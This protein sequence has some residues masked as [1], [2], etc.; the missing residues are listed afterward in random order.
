MNCAHC[1]SAAGNKD[2]EQS[3]C[4]T[5]GYSIVLPLCRS[6]YCRTEFITPCQLHFLKKFAKDRWRT[7]IS[8]Q[9]KSQF[10][11]FHFSASH[12]I[13]ISRKEH[14]YGTWKIP[15]KCLMVW[16][17]RS[18]IL[19]VMNKLSFVG[20]ASIVLL[21]PPSRGPKYVRS[22]ASYRPTP[23]GAQSPPS[24][25][26]VSMAINELFDETVGTPSYFMLP[27]VSGVDRYG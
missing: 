14:I 21:P 5:N 19:T 15:H 1:K 2:M 13:I 23:S 8:A 26:S 18:F 6:M 17:V 12:H 25:S 9:F 20:P 10:I 22:V 4:S 3:Q 27:C 24:R 7:L 11:S 16:K